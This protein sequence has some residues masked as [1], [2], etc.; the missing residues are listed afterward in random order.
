MKHAI[1]LAF[2]AAL[3]AQ[4]KIDLS[5]QVKNV[6]FSG[7]SATKPNRAGAS[8]PATCTQ[9]ET[10]FLT[11]APAG[12]NLYGCPNA[13]TWVLLSGGS[14]GGGG[15]TITPTATVSLTDLQISTI[16]STHLSIGAGCQPASPCVVRW[17]TQTIK[18]IAPAVLTITPGPNN[19]GTVF[20]WL[21]P[22]TTPVI[23]V[24]MSNFPTTGLGICSGCIVN[25]GVGQYPASSIPLGNWTVSQVPVLNSN[26]TSGFDSGGGED[27]RAFMSQKVNAS[28]P[29]I[30][31]ADTPG[32]TT[33]SVDTSVIPVQVAPPATSNDACSSGQFAFS[34]T[35]LYWCVAANTWRRVA[36]ATW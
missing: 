5:T 10:F 24:G 25:E 35:Y 9:A 28:G 26:P 33:V 4:T 11:T 15:V 22:N 21:D 27:L 29:G 12:Q 31:I 13:N 8:L 1:A 36:L 18:I 16:D 20:V 34:S 30:L 19:V 3:S 23:N 2:A 7:A 6:D 17:N 14:G 32:A